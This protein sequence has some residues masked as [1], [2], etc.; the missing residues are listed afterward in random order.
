[1]VSQHSILSTRFVTI[2]L[3]HCRF[4]SIVMMILPGRVWAQHSHISKIKGSFCL[5]NAI[6]VSYPLFRLADLLSRQGVNVS[7]GV[8]AKIYDRVETKKAQICRLSLPNIVRC[9][10]GVGISIVASCGIT[11]NIPV[12]CYV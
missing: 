9:H 1:M 10:M 11:R 8:T 5:Q 2:F 3:R 12:R 4:I 6:R 7:A